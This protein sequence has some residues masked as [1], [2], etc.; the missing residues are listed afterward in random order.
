ESDAGFHEH[1]ALLR[2]DTGSPSD[3]RNLVGH[4]APC[5]GSALRTQEI[6]PQQ[7]KVQGPKTEELTNPEPAPPELKQAPKTKESI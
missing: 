4:A 2:Q 5:G 7:P 1:F 3:L 6:K